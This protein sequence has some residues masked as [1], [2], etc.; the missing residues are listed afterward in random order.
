MNNQLRNIAS[1]AF[2]AV[3]A[4]GADDPQWFL[5]YSEKFAELLLVEVIGTIY[6]SDVGTRKQERLVEELACKFG[7]DK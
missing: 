2:D 5:K 1:N 4:E 3:A 7:F 6:R